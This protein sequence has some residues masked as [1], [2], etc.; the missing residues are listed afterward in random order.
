MLLFSPCLLLALTGDVSETL[1]TNSRLLVT[2]LGKTNSNVPD[3]ATEGRKVRRVPD[4]FSRLLRP[5][6]DMLL[7]P[8]VK[9]LHPKKANPPLP[10]LHKAEKPP[11]SSQKI[12]VGQ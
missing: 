5:F 3:R 4:Q 11:Y 1:G 12:P 10:V 2:S 7:A 8:P 6:L 9:P